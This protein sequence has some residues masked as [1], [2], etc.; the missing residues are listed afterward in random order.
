MMQVALRVAVGVLGAVGAVVL[1]QIWIDPTKIAEGLGLAA[2]GW[3]GQSA[4]RSEVA[5]FFGAAGLLSL[6][7]A[8]KNDRRLL[9]APVVLVAIALAGRFVQI[10]LDGWSGAVVPSIVAEAVLLAI[11]LAGYRSFRA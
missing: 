1:L 4:L 3:Q 9:V 6:A 10:A 11:Y 5:G 2:Q 8:V 7:S